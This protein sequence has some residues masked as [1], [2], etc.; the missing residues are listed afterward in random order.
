MSK[1]VWIILF[2]LTCLSTPAKAQSVLNFNYAED[3][4]RHTVDVPPVPLWIDQRSI[5][6]GSPENMPVPTGAKY[7]IFASEVNFYVKPVVTTGNVPTGDITDGTAWDRNPAQYRLDQLSGATSAVT[8]LRIDVATTG[9]VV[10][11][12]YK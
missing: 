12:F 2:A 10:A 5:T 3:A 6:A 1:F 11:K 8:N 4:A 9:V 7:V